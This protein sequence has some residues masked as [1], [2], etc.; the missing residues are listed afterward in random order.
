[1]LPL[2]RQNKDLHDHL[3][4]TLDIDT[5]GTAIR[6]GSI[7]NEDLGG[8]RIAPYVIRAKPKGSS[9]SWVFFLEIEAETVFLDANGKAVPLEKGKAIR[10]KLLGIKLTS[11]PESE[12]D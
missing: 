6:I 3:T 4:R 1:L 5:I 9:G 11:I 8:A 10:E 12:R 7:V 2:L